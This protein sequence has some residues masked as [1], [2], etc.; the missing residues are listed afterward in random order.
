[1]YLDF[2]GLLEQPFQLTPD[3][4]FLYLSKAHSRAKAYMD[5]A[6]LNRDGF[7]VITGEIGSG[8]T[9]LVQKLLSEMGEDTLIARVYQTQLDE[10][11]FLQAILVEFGFEPFSAGKVELLHRLNEFLS[12]QYAAGRKVVVIIDEAQNLSV[13]ALEE[14]RLLTGLETAKEKMLNVILVG[15]PELN[16][17]LDSPHLEQL[18]QRV[19]LRFHIGCLK[20]DEVAEYVAHR[21]AVA[22]AEQAETLFAEDTIPVIH[23]YTG[24][25]PR[26]INILCDT[27]LLSAFVDEQPE[28]GVEQVEKAIEELQWVPF[29]ERT[30]QRRHPP[31]GRES[32]RLHGSAPRLVLCFDGKPMD[33]YLLDKRVLTIGRKVDNDIQID[34]RTVSR[35]HVQITVVDTDYHLIDLNSRNGT[36]LNGRPVRQE[37]LKHGDRINVGDH[38]LH[39]LLEA[40]EHTEETGE[41]S[42]PVVEQT[43]SLPQIDEVQDGRG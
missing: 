12:A 34:S 26:L 25:V 6:V 14:L 22:G 11:E 17:V 3:P 10:V 20:P 41:Q 42:V 36:L 27:T 5:Y 37:R 39:F 21:L 7:A 9:M 13:R 15:Q 29:T 32:N 35:H 8:K 2:F 30:Y 33:E 18:A 23:A 38:E 19:R 40:S 16:D 31:Q 4:S 1:M 24:G 43:D 28:I